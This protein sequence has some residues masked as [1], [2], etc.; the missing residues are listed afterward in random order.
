MNITTFRPFLRPPP[1]WLAWT[2][3][4]DLA[5]AGFGVELAG[6]H[7]PCFSAD[8]WLLADRERYSVTRHCASLQMDLLAWSG[9][10]NMVYRDIHDLNPTQVLWSLICHHYFQTTQVVMDSNAREFIAIVYFLA[11]AL[12]HIAHKTVTLHTDNMN[13]AI[14]GT[15]GSNK[16]RLKGIVSRD[17]G[18]LQMILLDSLEV[19]STAGS[20]F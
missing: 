16:P 4:S 20:Y 7:P 11:S 10:S 9:I 2:D 8:N 18:E 13:A 3:A 15:S 1:T 19:L 14:I 12:P 17:W 5:I 6:V